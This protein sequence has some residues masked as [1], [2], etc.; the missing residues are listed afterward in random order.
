LRSKSIV[1][2]IVCKANHGRDWRDAYRHLG[3][4]K[5]SQRGEQVLYKS[6]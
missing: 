5:R 2:Q 3:A 1:G 6:G 4:T